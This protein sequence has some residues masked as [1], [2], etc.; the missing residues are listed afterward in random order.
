M[1]EGEREG[2]RENDRG[3]RGKERGIKD[4]GRERVQVH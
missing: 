2:G 3:K 4:R 1:G